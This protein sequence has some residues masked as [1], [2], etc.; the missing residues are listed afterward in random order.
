MAALVLRCLLYVSLVEVLCV[1]TADAAPKKG[2]KGESP[3]Q[4]YFDQKQTGDYNIQLHL[5]DFQIIA[6]VGDDSASLGDYDYSY[7]YSDFTIKP[8]TQKPTTS[9]PSTPI[10]PVISSSPTTPTTT[11]IPSKPPQH[12]Y[13]FVST[14][15]SSQP[16][17]NSTQSTSLL[18]ASKPP[19]S[20]PSSSTTSSAESSTKPAEE[21]SS[22]DRIKVQ[23]IE[24]PVR[25]GV[26][27]G[28]DIAEQNEAPH[29]DILQIKRCAQGFTRDKR[30]R[31]RRV[32]RPGSVQPH[33][34]YGF[35]RITSNLASRFR[36]ASD[37]NSASSSE[38]KE[39]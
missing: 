33:L 1:S 29:G 23:I 39:D 5:K 17:N 36:E 27:P 4:T 8:A 26:V 22:P 16:T 28:E 7:D 15:N 10:T 25:T 19:I 32:R 21:F 20:D 12:P 13:P 18:D 14:D 9:T 30:G 11:T 24:T 2:K 31:C 6:L 34:P 37:E 3:T 35:G 38:S